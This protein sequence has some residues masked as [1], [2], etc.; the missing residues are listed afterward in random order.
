MFCDITDL[1]FPNY[2]FTQ[3]VEPD[4]TD[5]IEH[6]KMF[7]FLIFSEKKKIQNCSKHY[8]PTLILVS[9]TANGTEWTTVK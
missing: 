2:S 1:A 7:L 5:D 6:Y 8:F 3:E 4:F 9:N